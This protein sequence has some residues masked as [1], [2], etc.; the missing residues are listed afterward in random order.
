[1]TT[2]HAD[3][4]LD[5][6]LRSAPW[7]PEDARTAS[8]FERVD[9]A[10][11]D[12]TTMLLI[13]AAVGGAASGRR[14]F[15]PVRPGDGG[16][17]EEARGNEAFDAAVLAHT[18]SSS[19]LPTAGGGRIEFRGHG[20]GPAEIRRMPFEQG[21]SSNALSLVEVSGTPCMHKT[22]RRLDETVHEPELLRRLSGGGHTP[23]WVGDYTYVDPSGTGRHPLGVVYRYARGHGI[24]VPLRQNLRSLWPVLS[25]APGTALDELVRSHLRPLERPLKAAGRFLRGFH[26]ELAARLPGTVDYPVDH[27]LAQARAAVEDLERHPAGTALPR[28]ARAEAFD[29]LRTELNGLHHD[30][31]GLRLLSGPC[32]GDLHLSHLLYADT[33]DGWR[34]TVIDLSTP[35]LSS[36]ERRWAD[37]SPLQD[38]VAVERALEYFSADEA[39]F[40]T[41]RRLGADSLDAMAGALDGAPEWAPDRRAVLRDVFG[42]ADLWREQVLRLFLGDLTDHPLRRLLYVRRLLHELAYNQAHARPYHAAIDLRHARGLTRTTSLTGT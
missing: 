42:A 26:R 35:A 8:R 29:A 19:R 22:Y 37:Q 13:V 20:P 33:E 27:A 3:A 40:E 16:S 24:D 1:M 41:A 21:W 18:L 39:A 5:A 30:F 34:M 25:E 6:L 36:A 2:P 10:L 9:H 17:V 38:L 15:V 7:M 4:A 12:E 31:K 23:E 28:A 14:Y 32:H 11:L